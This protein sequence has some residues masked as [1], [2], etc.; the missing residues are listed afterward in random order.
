ME[1]GR[2]TETRGGILEAGLWGTGPGGVEEIE[3]WDGS[4]RCRHYL[5]EEVSIWVRQVHPYGAS[6]IPEEHPAWPFTHHCL[7]LNLEGHSCPWHIKAGMFL[8]PEMS[9]TTIVLHVSE[10]GHQRQEQD[11]GGSV[12]VRHSKHSRQVVN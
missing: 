1:S 11:A 3:S 6:D 7:V 9:L 5:H 10:S 4:Q 12:S 2:D 8:C